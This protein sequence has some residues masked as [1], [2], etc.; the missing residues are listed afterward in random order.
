[1]KATV[2]APTK[3]SEAIRMAL[4]DQLVAEK[5]P[6]LIVD[7]ASW[8]YP[9]AGKCQICFAGAVMHHRFNIDAYTQADPTHFDKEWS[10]VFRA[11]NA[12]RQGY[13]GYALGVM[14]YGSR[15]EAV[16][17]AIGLCHKHGLSLHEYVTPYL[18][19]RKKFR[20]QMFSIAKQLE[21]KGL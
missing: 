16:K 19:D 8:H 10:R 3:L 20:K 11:L 14:K 17:K 18:K 7:M 9:N 13:V 1:M 15:D 4:K 5:N 6:E 2:S 21:E 12:V